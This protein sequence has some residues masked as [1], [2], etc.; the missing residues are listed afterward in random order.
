MK[1]CHTEDE[2]A[3]IRGILQTLKASG[4]LA[5][6]GV[7]EGATAKLMQEELPERNIHLF[8]TFTGIL[9]HQ[10][11]ENW[12]NGDY[13]C[14]LE[15]VKRNLRDGFVYHKGDIVGT[16][17]SVA[18]ETFAFIHID[19]DI[20]APLISSLPFFYERLSEGGT[21]AVSNHDDAHPGV[22]LAVREFNQ[23]YKKYSRYALFQK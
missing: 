21:M 1:T 10:E 18:E 13:Y 12:K 3:Y 5:E 9:Q 16:K 2:R 14:Q 11:E 17:T 7:Y 15:E 22:K 19:L 6:I 4:N 23:P 8:D 20:Y